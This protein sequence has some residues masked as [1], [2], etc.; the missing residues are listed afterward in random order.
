MSK[1][2]VIWRS[3]S[4]TKGP[5]RRRVS[6]LLLMKKKLTFVSQMTAMCQTH[7]SHVTVIRSPIRRRSRIRRRI[8]NR[9]RRR[10]KL[11]LTACLTS[12]HPLDL[13]PWFPCR[14]LSRKWRHTCVNALSIPWTRMRCEVPRRG[15]TIT[16]WNKATSS[17][18]GSPKPQFGRRTML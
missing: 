16:T 1:G 11:R 6:F 10:K 2:S 8:R 7:V 15:F 14:D 18:T 13:L 5:G 3:C 12:P 4:S 9:R 17:E